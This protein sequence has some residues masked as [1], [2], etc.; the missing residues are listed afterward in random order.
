MQFLH[1]LDPLQLSWQ[2]ITNGTGWIS[3][4]SN[5]SLAKVRI[6]HNSA[7]T[8]A[9]THSFW[10]RKVYISSWFLFFF[11][12]IQM[13]SA[14]RVVMNISIL[15]PSALQCFRLKNYS[16]T[17]KKRVLCW[18]GPGSHCRVVDDHLFQ[19]LILLRSRERVPLFRILNHL[20]TPCQEGNFH[21]KTLLWPVRLCFRYSRR[22]RPRLSSGIS[23]TVLLPITTIKRVFLSRQ[24]HSYALIL[25]PEY[26]DDNY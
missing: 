12:G 9:F 16:E 4:K 10:N 13:W 21:F 5:Q 19:T 15:T 17:S 11:L 18:R 1:F 22:Y 26:N 3:P 24:H 8:K 2:A 23:S 14:R 6:P 20:N 7:T 25:N